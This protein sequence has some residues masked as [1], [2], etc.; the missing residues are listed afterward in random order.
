M[1]FQQ[2]RD[3]GATHH[4]PG[5]HF[6][7]VFAEVGGQAHFTAGN[8]EHAEAQF[9]AVAALFRPLQAGTTVGNSV[10]TSFYRKAAVLADFIEG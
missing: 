1:L 10:S 9:R 6:A 4:L 5:H 7:A 3:A 2:M 8:R